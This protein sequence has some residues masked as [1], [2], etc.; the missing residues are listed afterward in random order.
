[1]S[2]RCGLSDGPWQLELVWPSCL[3][4]VIM[5]GKQ[6]ALVPAQGVHISAILL[7]PDNVGK[8]KEQ[9]EEEEDGVGPCLPVT[10]RNCLPLQGIS[11]LEKLVKTCPVWLHLGLGRAE[12]TKILHREAAGTFLVCRDSSLKHLVLCVHFP[13]PNESSSAVLE[14]TIKEEK[15]IL[16]LIESSQALGD[17]AAQTPGVY[18]PLEV[19]ERV[20]LL[21]FNTNIRKVAESGE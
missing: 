12:A 4:T 5:A 13:S 2:I 17:L 8:G 6:P 21:N 14:Y 18:N 19:Q 7:E 16:L 1:M 11:V 20:V 15:S 10:P 3:I 9:E